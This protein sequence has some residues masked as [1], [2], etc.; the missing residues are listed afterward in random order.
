[1]YRKLPKNVLGPVPTE[2]RT[3]DDAIVVIDN[4]TYNIADLELIDS[5]GVPK[6]TISRTILH[7]GQQTRG[8]SHANEDEVYY[9]VDG[10]GFMILN[11]TALMVTAGDYVLVEKTVFHKIVNT[12]KA[13][14]D[15]IFI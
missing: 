2:P 5:Q 9:F 4:D 10:D 12:S 14:G 7:G 15:L 1:M 8:H 13:G 11:N 3:L 6:I